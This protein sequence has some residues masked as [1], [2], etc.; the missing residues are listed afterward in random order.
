MPHTASRHTNGQYFKSYHNQAT[1]TSGPERGT[2]AKAMWA[3]PEGLVTTR[4]RTEID[5]KAAQT[6]E[7]TRYLGQPGPGEDFPE[8]VGAPDGVGSSWISF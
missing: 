6:I 4:M 5:H 1:H 8:I 2:K 7:N 3:K